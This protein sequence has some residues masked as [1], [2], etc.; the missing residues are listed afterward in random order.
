[1]S[2]FEFK[3]PQC[4][5]GVT[6]D[7]T[8]RGEIARCPI[9]KRR[10]VVPPTLTHLD[11]IKTGK[12]LSIKKTGIPVIGWLFITLGVLAIIGATII[13]VGIYVLNRS[14]TAQVD[15]YTLKADMATIRSH[16]KNIEDACMVYNMKHG[17]KYPN[18]FSELLEG[19]DDNPP[20]IDGGLEDPWGNKIKYE[21]KGK[22]IYLR[23]LGPDGKEGPKDDITN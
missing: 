4:N 17:G 6:A 20:L 21:K 13:I 23:S 2:Q 8:L 15:S 11:E 5:H 16:I 12:S 10:I 1:M 22:R 14:V 7:E 3:C 19:D 18:Q 9:C